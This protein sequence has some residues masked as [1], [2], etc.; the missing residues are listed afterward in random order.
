MTFILI[1]RG[2]I[3]PFFKPIMR[4]IF[5][6]GLATFLTIYLV[7]CNASGGHPLTTGNSEKADV[8]FMQ[9][10]G[11]ASTQ[12]PAAPVKPIVPQLKNLNPQPTDEIPCKNFVAPGSPIDI[13]IPDG[14]AL[15]PSEHFT[16]TWRLVNTG[17]CTWD[18]N[19]AIVWFSGSAFGDNHQQ[20]LSHS[21][22]PGGSMDISIEM[23]APQTPGSYQSNWKL[24][25][26]DGFFFGIG[27]DGNA[28]FWVNIQVV[29]SEPI[30]DETPAIQ[31]AA[32]DLLQQGAAD[33]TL[34]NLPRNALD[35]NGS[36][37]LVTTEEGSRIIL[38]PDGVGFAAFGSQIP[39]A[40][41][42][43]N[44]VYEM[45]SLPADEQMIGMYFCL[46]DDQGKI[47]YLR[48]D[49]IDVS[50]NG[51]EIQSFTW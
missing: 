15:A 1:N 26:P 16:K 36:F 7:A 49:S 39:S 43:A 24:R 21:V 38:G 42:C 8:L 9:P 12:V 14:S 51:V 2:T 45:T 4:K 10:M 13:T 31:P 11:P 46:K 41:Y 35:L 3:E 40:E 22:A 23:V 37:R 34:V 33:E 17:D 48:L 19:Y 25:A 29:V 30:Q 28:P 20:Y 6:L 32:Q 5:G 47:S 18:K 44:A 50:Q 27:P